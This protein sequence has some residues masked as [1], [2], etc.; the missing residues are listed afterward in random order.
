MFCFVKGQLEHIKFFNDVCVLPKQTAVLN[1]LFGYSRMSHI[2]RTI[3]PDLLLFLAVLY[4][5]LLARDD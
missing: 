1:I 5:N 4:S 2:I 3:L